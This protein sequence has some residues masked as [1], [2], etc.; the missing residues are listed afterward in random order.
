MA[1]LFTT[2]FESG[3]IAFD[4]WSVPTNATISTD[5]RSGGFSAAFSNAA[6]ASNKFL[7]LT[8]TLTQG[9][10]YYLRAAIKFTAWPSGGIGSRFMGIGDTTEAH[11]IVFP[12]GTID[13]QWTGPTFQTALNTWYVFE[14]AYTTNT[15]DDFI[16]WRVDGTVVTSA[17][18]PITPSAPLQRFSI[19]I[20]NSDTSIALVADDVALNDSTG[21]SQNSYP[22]DGKVVNLAPVAD[23]ARGT[24]WTAGAGGT[25]NLWD[26]VDNEPP[27]GVVLGSASNTSQ[28]K[29]AAKDVAGTY[30]AAVEAYS[31]TLASGGGGIA[32]GDTVTLVQ[33]VASVGN[34]TTTVRS[35]G[36]AGVS[37]PV[38][39][40]ALV[41][42][43][44]VAAA[45]FPTGWNRLAGTVVYGDIASGSRAT[46]PVI[47][48][49]KNT[50][51]TDSAMASYMALMVEYAPAGGGGSTVY[52]QTQPLMV[53]AASV[54]AATR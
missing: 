44:A 50:S 41:N 23:S 33:P 18:T 16:E 3:A 25:T 8:Q 47:R 21:A 13:T 14:I 45:T 2:G 40:E 22:G 24:N 15:G 28:V 42:N 11:L 17:T 53:N 48:L 6:G 27:V 38:A 30:D 4:P 51:S 49:R 39:A 19:G 37:N 20:A 54:R 34:S 9:T 5:A 46:R 12:D 32:A 26:A 35:F 43:T 1:R 52:P 29:N 10:T 31:A 36:L 7:T